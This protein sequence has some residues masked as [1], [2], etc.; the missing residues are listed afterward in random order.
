MASV[1]RRYSHEEIA[2]RGDEIYKSE[3]RP[4]LKRSDK[5]RFAAID[6]ETHEFALADDVL[7]A[8]HQLRARVP[9]AQVWLV[10]VGFPYVY[11]FG[12]AGARNLA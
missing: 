7:S 11:R 5:G 8:S 6:I 9:E 3:V 12:M 10:R 1:E 2:R 4:Q